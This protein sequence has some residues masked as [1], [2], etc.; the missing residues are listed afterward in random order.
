LFVARPAHHNFA[1]SPWGDQ[2]TE[3]AKQ[4][5][6]VDMF[7][8][9]LYLDSDRAIIDATEK[10]A[11]DRGVPMARIALAWV[12]RNPVVDAVLSGATTPHHLADAVA[13]LEITLTDD[14]LRALEEPY[15]PRTPTYFQ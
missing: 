8:N 6:K 10:I 15:V 14:E 3:R 13:A 4:N 1:V 11:A 7:D 5:P 9:P 12:L 2:N